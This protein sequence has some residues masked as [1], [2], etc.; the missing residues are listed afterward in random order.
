[1]LVALNLLGL[2]RVGLGKL[3]A[4]LLLLLLA[5]AVLLDLVQKL[6][7]IGK[8]VGNAR[9]LLQFAP[10]FWVLLG[11]L[12]GLALL[13]GRCLFDLV[14]QPNRRPLGLGLCKE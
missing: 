4:T 7:L 13:R 8:Q 6:L 3:A 1:M 2:C 10:P 9:V 14:P 5:N 12:S 11:E